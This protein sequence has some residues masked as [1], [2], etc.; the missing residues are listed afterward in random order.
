MSTP[1][2]DRARRAIGRVLVHGEHKHP[3]RGDA[4][5]SRPAL[6]DLAA[7]LRHLSRAIEDPTSRDE[8]SGELH[9]A[10]VAARVM[11]ALERIERR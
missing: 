6:R 7:A 10:H 1:D 5:L 11:L 3:G 4:W 2:L 8:E 9:L